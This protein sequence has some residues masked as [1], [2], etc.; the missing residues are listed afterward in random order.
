M[1]PWKLYDDLIENIPDNL[2]VL[3]CNSGNNWTTVTSSE[4]SIGLSM[5]IPVFSKPY[6]ETRRISGLPLKQVAMLA[7]SWNFVEAAIGVA[8]INSY[9]NHPLHSKECGIIHASM[10]KNNSD[11]FNL[12]Q[13]E[14]KGKKV[15]VI[16]HFPML[17]ERFGN[18][19]DLSILE[20][21]PSWGDYPDTA[22]EYILSE[23]DYVFI[24]G[25]TLVNKTL[26]RLLTLAKNTKIIMVG[27]STTMSSILFES[28]IFGLS[29][30]IV[31]DVKN[32][33]L[34]LREGNTME[35]FNTG[36]MVDFINPDYK[37]NQ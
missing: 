8:A 11:A 7:K 13:D 35:L 25:C 36:N 2:S 26:P 3:Y 16:G 31:N 4:N 14:V 29:G 21:N 5:T 17:E 12:Y 9:Y 6:M 32:C 1:N 34:I 30:F 28:G 18:I 37:N 15:A 23:Q 24:T 27:P 33:E 20:R 22:C 10:N 19:C